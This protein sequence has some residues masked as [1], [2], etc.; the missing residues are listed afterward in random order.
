[1]KIIRIFPRKT[2]ATPDDVDVRINALHP[3]L[4]DEADEIHI[5]T[6]F[7]WDIP[8]AELIAKNW[9][10]VAPVK[11][12]G[13]AFN[14]PGGD[15]VPGMY[16]KK[17]YVITSRGCPNRCWFCS[18]PRR[19]GFQL[20][21]LP[22][23]EGHILTDDNLLACSPGHIDG[24]FNM[25][26]RQPQRPSFTGGLEA[27]LMTPEHAARLRALRPRTVFFAYD[28]PDDLEPLIQAGQYLFN[29]GFTKQSRV[30]RAYVL[31]GYKGDTF[32]KAIGR[33]TETWD[34]G[35]FPMAMLYRDYK[36]DYSKD[37]KRLQREWANPILTGIKCNELDRR[38]L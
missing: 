18:V 4:S 30:L 9:Q 11:I 15:F 21:E 29:A 38:L 19:E 7:T 5:S 6:T 24:V 26:A 3:A 22:I 14:E 1:M 32:E 13:P 16:M 12:G 37:W 27:K 34:A 8:T 20:R 23:T 28:T 10:H 2:N 35:F 36:G 25:L 33:L 17:G 31:I